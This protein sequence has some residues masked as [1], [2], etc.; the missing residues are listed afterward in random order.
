LDPHLFS[1][2]F[3]AGAFTGNIDVQAASL[4]LFTGIGNNVFTRITPGMLDLDP[5]SDG[6]NIRVRRHHVPLGLDSRGGCP[7]LVVGRR[8]IFS[9][10]GRLPG[11]QSNSKHQQSGYRD[12][13]VHP[14]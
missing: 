12:D 6:Q 13:F 9:I 3:P 11:L 8:H 10:E 1:S 7:R 14:C 4:D 2:E 5:A